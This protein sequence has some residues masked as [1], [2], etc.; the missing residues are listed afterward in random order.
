[1]GILSI[2]AACNETYNFLQTEWKAMSEKEQQEILMNYRLAY[3]ADTMVNWCPALGTVLA[4]DEVSEGFSVRGGHPVERKT[5][6]QWSLRITAYADRLLKGLDEIDWSESIKE[7]QRNWIGKS[8]GAMIKFPIK[9][10]DGL[11]H[12]NVYH[13][14]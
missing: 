14:S 6:K 7:I 1:M 4:N 12:G 9:G 2:D 10:H 8:E 3:L 13:S 5:M 11:I